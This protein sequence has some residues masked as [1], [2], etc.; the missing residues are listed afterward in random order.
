MSLKLFRYFVALLLMGFWIWVVCD[1][2]LFS[3]P[4][5]LMVAGTILFALNLRWPT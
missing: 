1:Q 3:I 4:I 5:A 2:G